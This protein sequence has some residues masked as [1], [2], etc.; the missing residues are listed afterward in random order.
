MV[1]LLSRILV[2]YV[3]PLGWL[4]WLLQSIRVIVL[5]MAWWFF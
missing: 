1:F 4:S 5:G 2:L 3:V